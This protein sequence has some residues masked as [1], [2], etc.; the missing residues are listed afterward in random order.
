MESGGGGWSWGDG[1]GGDWGRGVKVGGWSRVRGVGV[2]AL[3]VGVRGVGGIG[4]GV[5]GEWDQGVGV[6]AW[7]QGGWGRRGW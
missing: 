4:V 5:G 7:S 1:V 2:R 6:G 3:R